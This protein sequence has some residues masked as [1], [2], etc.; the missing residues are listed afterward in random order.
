MSGKPIVIL[1]CISVV[2]RRGVKYMNNV[3]KK[4][5]VVTGDRCLVFVYNINILIKQSVKVKY[6]FFSVLGRW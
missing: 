3:I 6:I 4:K 1:K 5:I 2:A